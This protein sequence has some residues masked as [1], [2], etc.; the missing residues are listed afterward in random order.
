MG[1]I[2]GPVVATSETGVQLALGNPGIQ[3]PPGRPG[4]PGAQGIQGGSL[5][6]PSALAFSVVDCAVGR[7]AQGSSGMGSIEV[8]F[9]GSGPWSPAGVGFGV[10]QAGHFC[11]GARYFWGDTHPLEIA[12]WRADGTKLAIAAGG[13][14]V[15]GG[16]A[17]AS[18]ASPVA[19][20]P[21]TKYCITFLDTYVHG[22]GNPD[23]ATFWY[24]AGTGHAGMIDMSQFMP[25]GGNETVSIGPFAVLCDFL[26]TS[27]PNRI[28][29]LGGFHT[30][31]GN[32][33]PFDG[34]TYWYPIEPMLI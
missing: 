7:G 27:Q 22:V 30:G 25:Y 17:T 34:N 15:G 29:G 16:I 1:G 26:G 23:Y 33:V 3:G 18:F 12:L 4:S 2:S 31:G 11:T 14:G 24:Y 13:G 21:G 6:G 32:V 20:T 5:P 19:L 8:D 9:P 28:Y 10:T